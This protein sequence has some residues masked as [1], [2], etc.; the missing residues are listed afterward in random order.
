MKYVA[1]LLY[2]IIEDDKEKPERANIPV[3]I[4]L[5]EGG[6][7][8]EININSADDVNLVSEMEQ[9]ITHKNITLYLPP[10]QDGKDMQVA[11][12][13][14]EV[15]LNN[16]LSLHMQL[17]VE[18]HS[19]GKKIEVFYLNMTNAT[20]VQRPHIVTIENGPMLKVILR[21]PEAYWGHGKMIENEMIMEEM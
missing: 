1:I 12:T 7:N 20:L 8:R 9:A 21:F 16:K 11:L 18:K 19:K 3:G 17:I 4:F 2:A 15:A 13:L 5:V 14:T 6:T 10:T